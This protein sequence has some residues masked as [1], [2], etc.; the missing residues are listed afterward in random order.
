MSAAGGI[1]GVMAEARYV[2]EKDEHGHWL[3]HDT[4]TPRRY[5][6]PGYFVDKDRAETVAQRYNRIQA[7]AR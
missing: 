5:P 4:S 6:M 1:V 3:I 2:V 7:G